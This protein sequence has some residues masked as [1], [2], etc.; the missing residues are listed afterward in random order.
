VKCYTYPCTRKFQLFVASAL[1]WTALF[2]IVNYTVTAK[3]LKKKDLD[4]IKNRIVSILH[5]S[6]SFTTAV[7]HMYFDWPPYGS[8]NTIHQ[9]IL[10]LISCGYF[11]YDMIACAYYGLTDAGLI[12]HHSMTIIGEIACFVFNYGATEA[13]YGLFIA[14]CS[15]FPMHT[16]M[17]LKTLNLRYTLAYE[18]L[19]IW[20]MVTYSFARGILAPIMCYGAVPQP[21]TPLLEKIPMCGL[22]LQSQYYIYEM[23]KILRRRFQ[24][25]KE[26]RAKKVELAW[27][28]EVPELSQLS[29]YQRETKQKIF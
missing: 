3:N 1:A 20:Y 17:I 19:D 15:N 7:L 2:M 6:F 29:F 5:G 8:E 28:K 27:F 11:F 9:E 16:R 12:I 13:I 10:I 21:N 14:E 25:L 26:R 22:V 23:S 18:V 24:Q 4:D